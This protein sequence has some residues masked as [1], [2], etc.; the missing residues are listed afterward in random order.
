MKQLILIIILAGGGYYFY[1]HGFLNVFNKLKLSPKEFVSDIK[2]AT[3]IA[4]AAKTLPVRAQ[5]RTCAACS[6]NRP[7]LYSLETAAFTAYDAKAVFALLELS[8][9]SGLND[10]ERIMNKYLTNF[11]GSGDKGRVLT[12]MTKYQDKETLRYLVRFFNNG[13]FARRTLLRKIAE[14]KVS[15]SAAVI[16]IALEDKNAGVR[17]E[18]EQLDEE[19]KDEAWYIDNKKLTLPLKHLEDLMNIPLAN[20]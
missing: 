2:S 20:N 11:S 6:A 16:K 4:A 12:L 5:E 9:Y 8:Y 14:Y 7:S 18:A 15:E 13:T 3:S 1:T 19:L 10:T 17:A